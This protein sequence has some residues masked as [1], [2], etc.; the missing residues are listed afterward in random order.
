MQFELLAETI[1]AES[2]RAVDSASAR[3]YAVSVVR[4]SW[5]I[6]LVTVRWL[7][8]SVKIRHWE[9][10]ER[11][12]S[13]WLDSGGYRRIRLSR[14]CIVAETI[15]RDWWKVIGSDLSIAHDGSFGRESASKSGSSGGGRRE[16]WCSV[17][18]ASPSRRSPCGETGPTRPPVT[19][20]VYLRPLFRVTGYFG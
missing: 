1:V 2:A 10:D 16:A 5:R 4:I 14:H 18:S 9:R 15:F 20:S 12:N 11:P 6:A 19:D 17:V 3:R 7:Y 8:W 13:P